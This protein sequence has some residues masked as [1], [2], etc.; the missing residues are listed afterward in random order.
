MPCRKGSGSGLGFGAPLVS[1]PRCFWAIA[2]TQAR[3]QYALA[4]ENES[5]KAMVAFNRLSSPQ[6]ARASP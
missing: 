2:D 3:S 4:S 6:E 1:C 5:V